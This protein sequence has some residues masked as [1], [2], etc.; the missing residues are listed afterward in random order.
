[1]YLQFCT[2]H[3]LVSFFIVQCCEYL[4]EI[5]GMGI[6]VICL[7]FVSLQADGGAESAIWTFCLQAYNLC[8]FYTSFSCN[9]V[10]RI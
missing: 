4:E 1:M 8:S 3:D 10:V 2:L 5:S 9:V 7:L 6:H